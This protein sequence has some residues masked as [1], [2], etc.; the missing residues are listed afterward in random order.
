MSLSEKLQDLHVEVSA[1][2]ERAVS[3]LRQ[4]LSERLRSSNEDLVRRVEEFTPE[5]PAALFSHE[6]FAYI[7]HGAGA[8]ARHGALSEL[9][10]DL[11]AID[12]ERSQA[13]ILR[14]LLTAACHHASRAAI[15]LT[16]ADG[17][18]GWGS[19]GFGDGGS[20]LQ[21]L[22]LPATPGSSWEKLAAGHGPVH[23]SAAEAADLS[24]RLEVPIPKAALLVP[25]VLRDRVAAALYADG[26]EDVAPTLE[27]LQILAYV[28]AQAIETLPFR[29]RGATSTLGAEA[30]SG[31]AALGFWPPAAE[32][33]AAESAAEPSPAPAAQPVAAEPAFEASAPAAYEAP[34]AVEQPL[35]VSTQQSTFEPSA[36]EAPAERQYPRSVE[37][38]APA[39]ASQNA[40][41]LMPRP[42]FLGGE[43][44]APA[45]P[46]SFAPPSPFLEPPPVRLD[47]APATTGTFEEPPAPPPAMPGT[48]E[49]KPPTDVDGPG[50]AFATTRVSVGPG[51][52][53]V[54][55]EAR[56]LARLLVSE[57]K[58]YNEEQVEEGRRNRDIYERLKEDIDRSRQMYEER[59]DE[60]IRLTTDYFYQE[61]VRILAAGDSKALGI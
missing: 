6:G 48:A 47:H 9:R 61:L 37:P 22:S 46:A 41:V 18:K 7:E 42:T 60:R 45:Q 49:V 51:E 55:E 44:I 11:A 5:V 2:I 35:P 53:A 33:P 56:R 17:I 8:R 36:P 39:E 3:A 27:S 23:L 34:P 43:P 29:E 20:G 19:E 15:F 58:L 12:R 14:S 10:D 38:V 30:S 24:S 1:A 16:R 59:V 26:L 28:S 54:H 40:T 4:D 13:D 32:A 21:S 57:I 31:G 25:L 52:E 50:W